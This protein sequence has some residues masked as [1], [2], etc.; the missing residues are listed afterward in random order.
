MKI[1]LRNKGEPNDL[2]RCPHV[3]ADVDIS[4]ITCKDNLCTDCIR[5]VQVYWK[6]ELRQANLL[7]ITRTI[8]PYDASHHVILELS[9][10]E[11]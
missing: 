6:G 1:N 4:N 9:L 3:P 10:Y 7:N 5:T 2:R 8:N 11:N